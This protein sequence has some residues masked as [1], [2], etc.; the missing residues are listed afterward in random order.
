M[1]H[2]DITCAWVKYSDIRPLGHIVEPHILL[3]TVAV[4]IDLFTYNGI[5]SCNTFDTKSTENSY[6]YCIANTTATLLLCEPATKQSG[7]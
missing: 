3:T 6:A 2:H 1:Q 5:S 7:S 4:M